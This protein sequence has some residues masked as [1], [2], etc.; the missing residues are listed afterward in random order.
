MQ[1]HFLALA[2]WQFRFTFFGQIVPYGRFCGG[3]AG[4][5]RSNVVLV[6]R[7]ETFYENQRLSLAT[8]VPSMA[9]GVN[10]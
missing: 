6:I 3:E 8:F 10:H 1:L 5:T 4:E 9:A 7:T 2:S